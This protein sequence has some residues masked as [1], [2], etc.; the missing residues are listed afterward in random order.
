[1]S[2]QPLAIRDQQKKQVTCKFAIRTCPHCLSEYIL[3]MFGT[4]NGCDACEGIVRNPRDGTI[5]NMDIN[6]EEFIKRI[7]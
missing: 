7:S 1:M 2:N 3:G 6:E 4:V 5:I